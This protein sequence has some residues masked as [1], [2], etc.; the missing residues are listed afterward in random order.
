MTTVKQQLANVKNAKLGGVKTEEGKERSKYNAITHGILRLSIT[1][2]ERD[3]RQFCLEELLEEYQPVGFVETML[4]ERMALCYLRFF[5]VARVEKEK[6]EA[7]LRPHIEK[8]LG[9]QISDIDKEVVQKGYVPQVKVEAI[10]ILN[11]TTL[12]Y[13]TAIENKFYKV[14]HELE[15]LQRMRKGERIEAPTVVDVQ[16][17]GFVSQNEGRRTKALSLRAFREKRLYE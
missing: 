2:Y 4:V 12:R 8:T 15:R 5:R 3:M 9:E 11:Q 14:L 7:I 6:M 1:E 16:V 13:E 17:N 10:E